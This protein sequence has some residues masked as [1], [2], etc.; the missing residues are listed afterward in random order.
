LTYDERKGVNESEEQREHRLAHAREYYAANKDWMKA[1]AKE[2]HSK[3]RDAVLVKN[4][5]RYDS[6]PEHYRL[7]RKAWRDNN[8]EH[9]R[10]L[11]RKWSKARRLQNPGT[12]VR[13]AERNMRRRAQVKAGE[14]FTHDERNKY[15][16]AQGM[17]P[18]ICSYCDKKIKNWLS[19]VGDHVVPLSKGGTHTLD[20]VVPCCLSCNCSKHDRLLY[21]EW[22][23]PN[24]R[25]AA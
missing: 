6:N 25:H 19:S 8:L 16:E 2:Y 11:D 5:I 3:N 10:E 21:D 17:D 12:S 15:W 7:Q 9:A 1:R 4:K 18:K 23:P 20:N 22:T 14:D 13:E 24:A